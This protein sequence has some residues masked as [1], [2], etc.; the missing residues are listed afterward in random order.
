MPASPKTRLSKLPAVGCGLP[1]GRTTS[2][3][4]PVATQAGAGPTTALPAATGYG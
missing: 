4:R 2:V 1:E 3:L